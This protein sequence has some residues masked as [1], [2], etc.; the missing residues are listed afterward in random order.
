ML[1]VS[2]SAQSSALQTSNPAWAK[3][4]KVFDDSPKSLSYRVSQREFQRGTF[5]VQGFR[6]KDDRR[7]QG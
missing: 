5:L 4:F 6:P 3:E 2:A 7:T 1:P